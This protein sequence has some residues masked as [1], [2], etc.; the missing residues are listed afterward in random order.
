MLEPT[1]LVLV[2]V[3]KTPRDLEMARVLGW[4]RLPARTAP[5]ILAVDWL[6]FY[7][8]AAFGAEKWS[9]RCAAPVRGHELTTRGA[10]LRAEPDHP[11]AQALYYKLQLGLL[12]TL[13]Q[14]IPARRWR[15]LAF[16]YTTGERL[17]TATDIQDLVVGADERARLWQ[18]L[19]ERAGRAPAYTPAVGGA[20]DSALLA[21]LGLRRA[22]RPA[23]ET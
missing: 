14:P 23:P 8:T 3:V 5:K 2:A 15:R 16:L 11:R 12:E 4:Y 18:T 6:A 21:A 9:I 1:D 19:R 10:L 20:L 22:G 13:P 17:M 7:Q